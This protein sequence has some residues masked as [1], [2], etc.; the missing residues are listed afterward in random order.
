[1]FRKYMTKNIPDAETSIGA[2]ACCTR[3][4]KDLCFLKNTMSMR[5][6][7]ILIMY[8]FDSSNQQ[9]PGK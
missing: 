4:S 8:S 7:R 1:M 6:T 2:T 3:I 9:A 5:L